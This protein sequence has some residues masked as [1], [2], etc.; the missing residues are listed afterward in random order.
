MND[1]V[2]IGK[3]VRRLREARGLS[4]AALAERM[5]QAGWKW[6]QPTVAAIEKGER[7]LKFAEAMNLFSLPVLDVDDVTQLLTV[8]HVDMWWAATGNVVRRAEQLRDA[9]TIY[10]LAQDQLAQI[11]AGL[12]EAGFDVPEPEDEGMQLLRESGTEVV[13]AHLAR[14][15]DETP[16]SDG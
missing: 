12:T 1:D 4:Q 5:R 11:T 10:R 16:D 9:A 6:S 8:P 14:Q 3:N 2:R 15:F 13:R 7:S